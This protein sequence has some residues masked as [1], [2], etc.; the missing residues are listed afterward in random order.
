MS[1]LSW[2]WDGLVGLVKALIDAASSTLRSWVDGLVAGARTFAQDLVASVSSAL[3]NA[4]RTIWNALTPLQ[5]D[6]VNFKGYTLPRL[7]DAV[8]KAGT[9]ITQV[10]NNTY[11]YI[12]QN[13]TNVTNQIIQN[14]TQEITNVNNYITNVTGASEDWVRN[15][16]S[17]L[18]PADFIKDPV[19]YIGAA[20]NISAIIPADF[21]KDPL[22]YMEAAFNKFMEPWLLGPIDAFLK[23]FEEGIKEAETAKEA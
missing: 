7:W 10:L 13:A 18:I 5:F 23:G 12:T 3:D 22:G 4:K 1:V 8:A 2:I 21:I 14:I 19:G 17:T 11:N 9:Y 6:W 20:V 15:Q 16:F